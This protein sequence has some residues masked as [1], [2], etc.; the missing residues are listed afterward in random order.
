MM[1]RSFAPACVLL[2]A[3][4]ACAQP[5]SIGVVG[6]MGLTDAFN[7]QSFIGLNARSHFYSQA[8]DY[9]VGPMAGVNLPFG[10]GVEFDAL[11][12]P[13]HLTNAEFITVAPSFTNSGTVNT[14]EFPLLGKFRLPEHSIQPF[15]EA[16]PSFRRAA[17]SFSLLSNVSLLSNHGFTAGAGLQFHLL[18][19]RFAPQIRYTRWTADASPGTFVG[20]IP[21]SKLNQA[22]LLLGISY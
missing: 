17:T 21:S 22:V 10:L 2:L 3:T 8:K 16:G 14:W 18:K 7:D 13:V 5:F 11:Y 19:V 1:T 6:G 4:A 20:Q 15:V 12:R 9:L